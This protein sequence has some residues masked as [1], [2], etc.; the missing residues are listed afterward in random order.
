MKVQCPNCK[1]T[2]KDGINH[3][4]E[5]VCCEV[6]PAICCYKCKLCHLTEDHSDFVKLTRSDL[7]DFKIEEI[8]CNYEISVNF[9]ENKGRTTS[10]AY[11]IYCHLKS[12]HPNI[13]KFKINARSL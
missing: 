8:Q 3:L 12:N 5:L 10:P 9:T 6:C 4:D 13:H 7:Y 2:K 11:T 1:N